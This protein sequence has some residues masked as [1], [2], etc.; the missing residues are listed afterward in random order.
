MMLCY[1][2]YDIPIKGIW[3]FYFFL[4]QFLEKFHKNH[5]VFLKLQPLTLSY[6]Y[7]LSSL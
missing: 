5:Y 2:A 6:Y 7:S 3:Q 1:E 4:Q